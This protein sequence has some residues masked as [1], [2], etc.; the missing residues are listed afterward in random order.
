MTIKN[1]GHYIHA[2]SGCLHFRVMNTE[3]QDDGIVFLPE[4]ISAD[5]ITIEELD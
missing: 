5:P 3:V 1:I 4:T 2:R